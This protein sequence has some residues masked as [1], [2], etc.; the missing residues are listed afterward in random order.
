ME[1]LEAGPYSGMNSLYNAEVTSGIIIM[2]EAPYWVDIVI[3]D[4]TTE[5]SILVEDMY[6]AANEFAAMAVLV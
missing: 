2:S 6:F 4:A 1:N 5:D 3:T